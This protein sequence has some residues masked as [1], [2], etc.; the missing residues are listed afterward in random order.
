MKTAKRRSALIEALAHIQAARKMG[1]V[2]VAGSRSSGVQSSDRIHH[3]APATT[4][5]SH[6]S[7]QVAVFDRGTHHHLKGREPEQAQ[8][9][10]RKKGQLRT[11]QHCSA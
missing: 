6:K 7:W 11:C 8:C 3:S 1:L 10:Y 4:I 2:P 5:C 9:C